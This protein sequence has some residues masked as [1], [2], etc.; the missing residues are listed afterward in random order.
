MQEDGNAGP[1]SG[2]LCPLPA[3]GDVVELAHGSGGRRMHDL[4]REVFL[5]A[6]G[7]PLEARGHDSAVFH[8]AEG[9]VAFTT[10][11]YVV[12]PLEFPGGDIGSLAVHGTVNDLLAGG[13]RPRFLSASFILE[14]GLP[15]ATLRR[16]V[17]SMRSAAS[18]SDV[19]IVTGDTK[20]VERG[21]GDGVYITTSGVGLV[22]PGIAVSPL[23]VQPGDRVILSGDIGRHGIA[24]MAAREGLPFTPTITSDSAPLTSSILPLLDSGLAV[25]CLRDLTRGGLASAVIEL[26]ASAGADISIDENAIAV[27]DDVEAAC[28]LLGL[29]PLHVANEGRFIAVVPRDSAADVLALLAATPLAADARVIGEVAPGA[30]RVHVT[31]AVGT[32]R[33]LTMLSGEQLPRIC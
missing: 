28:E 13:A 26:A 8:A 16:L 2:P 21:H 30:G 32:R 5:P 3:A 33:P 24:I 31:T 15:L 10:D 25:H 23:R 11:A 17:D 7:D 14:A 19:A 1:F 4:L 27:R 29:D 18:A 9:H 6:F 20:V 12:R 22:P